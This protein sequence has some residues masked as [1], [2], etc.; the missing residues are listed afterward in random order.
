MSNKSVFKNNWN[1]I[2]YMLWIYIYWKNILSF[3]CIYKF[4]MNINYMHQLIY[5]F[6]KTNIYI[7]TL[8]ILL[9]WESRR[10]S[11]KI[12]SKISYLR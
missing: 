2:R 6:H 1:N 7:N 5:Y 8:K 12:S 4:A 10:E 3:N 11:K 9:T